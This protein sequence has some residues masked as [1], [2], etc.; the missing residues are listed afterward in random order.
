MKTEILTLCRYA[1]DNEG[2][3][4]IVDTFDTIVADK[5]P[6]REYFYVAAKINLIDNNPDYKKISMSI[7]H[8]GEET[9]EI[10]KATSPF[11]R[12]ENT[13]KI[14]ITAGFKGLIFEHE[15]NY[16]LRIHFDD[17]LVAELPFKVILRKQ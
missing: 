6:W 12:P 2:H 7:A 14:S 11:A 16:S 1:S 15:G 4:T 13:E 9:K 5:I 17:T 8:I 10:F 3:Q